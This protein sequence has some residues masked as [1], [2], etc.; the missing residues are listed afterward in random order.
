MELPD[1]VRKAHHLPEACVGL[2]ADELVK[3]VG[4]TVGRGAAGRPAVISLY[5]RVW[6]GRLEPGPVL[7][8]HVPPVRGELVQEQAGWHHAED[9]VVLG[10]QDGI[11]TK[12]LSH[13]FVKICWK[14][15]F[16][17]QVIDQG[18]FIWPVDKNHMVV[19]DNQFFF[20]LSRLLPPEWND[21]LL[22]GDEDRETLGQ[23][24][25]EVLLEI[26]TDFVDIFL[27]ITGGVGTLCC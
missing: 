23:L 1:E 8:P 25:L 15:Q 4:E 2:H 11:G 10:V 12:C 13:I 26:L 24:I 16:T 9:P 20:V 5:A 21:P 18:S 6:W 17:V 3:V 27:T 22:V 19:P 7:L 14:G